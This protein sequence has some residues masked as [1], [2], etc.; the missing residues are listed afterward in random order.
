MHYR[1]VL[2]F[3]AAAKPHSRRLLRYFFPY[4][5]RNLRWIWV[6]G[7]EGIVLNE[8]VDKGLP[9]R[10]SLCSLSFFLFQLRRSSLQPDLE[11]MV[12]II[13]YSKCC[14]IARFSAHSTPL[15]PKMVW[16]KGDR[17]SN[18]KTVIFSAHVCRVFCG[19]VLRCYFCFSIMYQLGPNEVLKN[20]NSKFMH[21]QN[22]PGD[23]SFILLLQWGTADVFPPSESERSCNSN[24]KTWSA[25]C[26]QCTVDILD[27]WHSDENVWS[28]TCT[29][30]NLTDLFDT[31]AV[32]NFNVISISATLYTAQ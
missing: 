11:S 29:H 25:I 7:H 1:C 26:F 10:P 19:N 30:V 14:F 9:C 28:A 22:W 32:N 24:T 4:H 17:S 2:K 16:N 31:P 3:T 18:G 5:L 6:P 20:A 13:A 12:F 27:L 8:V 15:E 23:L 21:P